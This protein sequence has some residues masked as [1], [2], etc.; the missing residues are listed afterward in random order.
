MVMHEE[1]LDKADVAKMLK[2]KDNNEDWHQY[3]RNHMTRTHFQKK[4]KWSSL[5]Q[6]PSKWKK[7]YHFR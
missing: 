1:M 6:N 5:P 4:V 7:H 2:A 3:K